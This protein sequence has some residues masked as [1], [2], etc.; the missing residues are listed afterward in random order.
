MGLEEF[1]RW[2]EAGGVLI[3]DALGVPAL[4]RYYDPALLKFPHRQ[5]AQDAFLA[6]ND[7]LYLSRFALTDD[8][9]AQ[10]QAIRE[11]ILFFQDKYGKDADFGARADAAVTRIL[12]MKLETAVRADS[13]HQR[14]P[15]A[16][17]LELVRT[18]PSPHRSRVPG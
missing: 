10:Y 13:T 9:Q 1:A 4:R 11:T 16:L 5:V 7:M 14:T 17:V 18:T 2:R 3:S 8:W 15:P 12:R 6:G